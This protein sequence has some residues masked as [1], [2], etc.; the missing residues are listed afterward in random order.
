M[1]GSDFAYDLINIV[2][3][4]PVRSALYGLDGRVRRNFDPQPGISG[5]FAGS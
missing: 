3:A 1:I 5:H 4:G 2:D